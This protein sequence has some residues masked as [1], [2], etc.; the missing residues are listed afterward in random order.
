MRSV[1]AQPANSAVSFFPCTAWR[2]GG[3]G[4]RR[5]NDTETNQFEDGAGIP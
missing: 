3:E 4:G 2:I 1:R 5:I